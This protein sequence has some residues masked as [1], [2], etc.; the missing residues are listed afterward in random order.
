MSELF[1]DDANALLA[2]MARHA[3]ELKCHAEICPQMSD[4]L[5]RNKINVCNR[6]S[7]D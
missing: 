7:E 2:N 1:C 6:L 5:C 4:F 3:Q